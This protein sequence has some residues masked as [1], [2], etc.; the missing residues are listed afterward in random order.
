MSGRIRDLLPWLLLA[1][2]LTGLTAAK[3]LHIDDTYYYYLARQIAS[4]PLDPYGFSGFWGQWPMPA[5]EMV[6]PAALSYWLALPLKLFGE[7]PPAWKIFLFPVALMLLVSAR[8]LG[9][10]IAPP[11]GGIV[12]LCIAFSPAVLP[13]FNLMLDV[14]QLAFALSSLAVMARAVDRGQVA[15]ALVAGLIAGLAAQIK[16]NGLLLPA[17]LFAYAAVFRRPGFGLVAACTAVAMFSLWEAGLYLKYGTSHFVN[18]VL[19]G[20]PE[21]PP[22][23]ESRSRLFL[24]L[25]SNLGMIA[26]L[27]AVAVVWALVGRSKRRYLAF[28]PVTLLAGVAGGW[29]ALIFTPHEEVVALLFGGLVVFAFLLAIG[30]LLRVL[31]N[32]SLKEGQASEA[33]RLSLF[34]LIWLGVELAAY[35][36]LSPFGAVRRV[37]GLYVV[38]ILVFFCVVAQAGPG[39]GGRRMLVLL[40]SLVGVTGAGVY[41]IDWKEADTSRRAANDAAAFIRSTDPAARIWYAGHWGF[42]YYADRQGMRPL[43]PDRSLVQAGDWLVLPQGIDRQFFQISPW[44]FRLVAEREYSHD[45]GLRTVPD[46]YVGLVPL[47]RQA[48]PQIVLSVFQAHQ[49]HVPP[50][51]FSVDYMIAWV[52]NRNGMQSAASGLPALL[53]WWDRVA[54][55]DRLRILDTLLGVAP[56]ARSA[57]PFLAQRFDR[58]SSEVR[59]QILR[60]MLEIG[61][62]EPS[63]MAIVRKAEVDPDE[64]VRSL[65]GSGRARLR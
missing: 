5:I 32:S 35:V 61:P 64:D 41:V 50:S 57:L 23:W 11:L 56:Y 46:Y 33:A 31:R 9:E 42:A 40:V 7:N 29:L 59:L 58:E 28:V 65:A 21:P 6:S 13:G 1:A 36:F 48:V 27:P 15:I 14:P 30:H 20:W 51:P 53:G 45:F 16:Y 47:R 34:L 44:A 18:A 22:G 24:A 63:A 55:A 37:M 60:A 10:R 4:D 52:G 26:A 43:I 49:T 3:P 2:V 25:F 19:H 54:T 8:N 62:L 39:W 38:A 17:L 12:A